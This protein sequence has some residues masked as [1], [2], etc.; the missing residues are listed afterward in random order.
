MRVLVTGGAGFIGSHIADAFDDVRVLDN[1]SSGFRVNVKDSAEFIEGDITNFDVVNKAMKDIDYVFHLAAFISVPDSVKFPEKTFE[2]NVKGTENVLKAAK[3]NGIKKVIFTSSAA[4]YGDNPNLPLKEDAELKPLSPYGKTKLEAERLCEQYNAVCL[5]P[6]N[7][8]GPRQNPNSP[9]S[10]VISIFINN[11]LQNK[12][13]VIYGDGTQT[14]DFVFVGDLVNAQMLAMKKGSGVYNVG[15]GRQISVNELSKK[16][17]EL[18][19]SKSK[20]RYAQPR[21]GEIKHSLADISRIKKAGF[22]VEHSFEEGLKK[23]EE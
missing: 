10:G 7:A 8:F 9:Y 12:D 4:V 21:K 11:A 20:I 16:V 2:I 17:I 14:R 19:G 22:E 23:S 15:S 1:L 6:F 5:R 13:L 3:E 18:T